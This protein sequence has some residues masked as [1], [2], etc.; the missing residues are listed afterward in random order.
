MIN[1]TKKD[2]IQV[3]IYYEFSKVF[4]HNQIKRIFSIIKR[5]AKIELSKEDY[6]YVIIEL[7]R[8]MFVH[9][10]TKLMHKRYYKKHDS[11]IYLNCLINALRN[12]GNY[13]IMNT[14]INRGGSH[15]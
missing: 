3:N 15:D 10:Y 8:L 4:T 12:T 7:D 9:G 5:I 14:S 6:R 13:H 11:E 1:M 2:V